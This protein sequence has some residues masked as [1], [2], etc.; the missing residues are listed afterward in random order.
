[1]KNKKTNDLVLA[2]IFVSMGLILPI[3]FHGFGGGGPVFLPM[4]IPVLIAGFFLELPFAIAVGILTPVLSSLLTG[5]PPVF[6]VL[7]YMAL[8]LTV[9]SAVVSLLYR[10]LKLNVYISLIISM[11]CGRIMAGIAVW[12]LITFFTVQLPSPVLFIQ[13][14][15][16]NGLPGIVI[17]LIL[18]PIIVLSTNRF[19]NTAV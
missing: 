19:K 4:H 2:G 7:P 13:G 8:E 9:Y 14:A 12:A 15:I 18:I 11:I 5:M 17:Q 1:M 16:I 6:P 3:V 10:K